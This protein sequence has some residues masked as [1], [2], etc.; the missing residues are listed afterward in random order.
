M[1]R[2]IKNAYRAAL[3]DEYESYRRAGRKAEADHVA[4]VLLAEHGHDVRGD[5]KTEKEAAV[6]SSPPENTA[7]TAPK[8]TAVEGKPDTARQDSAPARK[9]AAAK[10]TAAKPQAEGK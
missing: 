5:G 10:R 9:A 1:S 6:E 7:S 3:I 4:R 8:E 2:N